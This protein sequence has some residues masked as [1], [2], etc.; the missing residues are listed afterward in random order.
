MG[1]N[2]SLTF[3]TMTRRGEAIPVT[4]RVDTVQTLPQRR[5]RKKENERNKRTQGSKC[6]WVEYIYVKS[7]T[8]VEPRCGHKSLY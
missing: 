2:V 3:V 7:L 8:E 4:T 5:K 6:I 1:L